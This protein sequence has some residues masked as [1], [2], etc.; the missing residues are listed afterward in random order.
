MA[1][2]LFLRV[3]H[4]WKNSKQVKGIEG[5]TMKIV[6]MGLGFVGLTTALGL[7]EKGH[8]VLGF[9]TNASRTAE[10]I[11]GKVSLFEPNLTEA[12]THNLG[13][14]FT[15]LQT[16]PE[17]AADI[18]VFFIC[19]GTPC[20]DSGYT[21]FRYVF[22][23]LDILES[24]L[25]SDSFKG[26][27]AI[28]S[29]IPPGTTKTKIIPY[30][31]ERGITAPV[32]NN[33]EFLREGYC[34][35]DFMNPDRIVCGIEDD[36]AVNVMKSIYKDF[37]VPIV[38][39]SLN[40]AEFIKYLSNNMLASMISFS[41]E[42]SMIA[43][44]TGD[45]SVKQAFETLHMDRRWAGASMMHYVYPGCGFGG[46]CLPKELQAMISHAKNYGITPV[47][48]ESV[49]SVNRLM[50][51][52]FTDQI[53]V[54]VSENIGI[55]GLSFKPNSGDVRSTP[56]ANIISGLLNKGYQSIYAYDPEAN[57]S[58]QKEYSFPIHYCKSM[59]EVCEQAK[60]VLIVTA[61]P[62]FK[63]INKSW[64]DVKFIDGRY[65]L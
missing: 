22:G 32:V 1:L 34:W 31:R 27:I 19:V 35:E 57:V 53:T 16:L 15:V 51:S 55:L 20:D 40:T 10:L 38:V 36:G 52:F 47:I 17:I 49:Q 46:Y 30:L 2:N 58:F 9:D 63:E 26:V 60:T 56:A 42:M 50:A 64:L 54:D 59:D 41:N 28:K 4:F 62:Q 23:A 11:S 43:Q 29:T 6:V 33:P 39:T 8:T 3:L 12:L 65:M 18:Q 61:W 45:I 44:A 48:L 13:A 25:K 7:A 5:C 21:D 24:M 37:N 14:N